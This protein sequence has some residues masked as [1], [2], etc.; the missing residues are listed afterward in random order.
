MTRPFRLLGVWAH[1][2]DETYLSAALMR[3]VIAAGGDVTL[4]CATRGERATVEPPM[5]PSRLGAR[6]EHELRTAMSR[7]GVT[8]VRFLGHPDGGC[9]AVDPAVPVG[10]L[11]SAIRSSRPDLIV[12]FG[13]EG[14]TNHPDHR[15]VARWTTAAWLDTGGRARHRLLYATMT[16][17]FVERHRSAYPELPL[18]IEG[19][20]IAVPDDDV[21]LRIVPDADERARKRAA[22]EAHASQI[23]G[24]VELVGADR[25]H[26]W[27]EIETFREPTRDDVE[28]SPSLSGRRRGR[29]VDRA[30]PAPALPDARTPDPIR[31]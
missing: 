27:W 30:T 19:A 23:A 6:R 21:A 15:A 4:I 20:P 17:S 29:A 22:L 24:L 25:L 28:R 2:D 5:D 12:T 14:I 16:H 3:R 1:P 18:T 9:D 7:L 13:P 11:R 8:D 10:S 31:S 26:A